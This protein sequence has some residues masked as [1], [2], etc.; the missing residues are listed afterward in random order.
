MNIILCGPSGTGKTVVGKAVAKAIG[1]EWLDTDEAIEKEHG[2]I[3]KIFES[4]GEEYFRGIESRLVDSLKTS[5]KLVI[6][7]GGGLVVEK[8]NAFSLRKTGKIV[9]LRAREE[10]LLERLKNC[11]DRPLLLGENGRENFLKRVRARFE[12]YESVAD[13]VIDVDGLSVSETA[14]RV[15]EYIRDNGII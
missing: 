4:R 9:Y 7:T 6:S 10:T 12:V 15:I 14:L 2:A 5:D 8:S 13:F 3:T 11:Q 1:W